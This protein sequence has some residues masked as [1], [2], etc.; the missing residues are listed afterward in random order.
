M[1]NGLTMEKMKASPTFICPGLRAA[2]EEEATLLNT[3]GVAV[4]WNE[5]IMVR[6]DII[7]AT[8]KR[9]HKRIGTKKLLQPFLI[10][11]KNRKN[12]QQV[13]DSR[14]DSSI[15]CRKQTNHFST[16]RYLIRKVHQPVRSIVSQCHSP[17]ATCTFAAT[18]QPLHSP[19]PN[20]P[21]YTF[22]IPSDPLGEIQE[23]ARRSN[24]MKR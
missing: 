12:G 6:G 19:L 5:W 23:L 8:K 4:T 2:P 1:Q 22:P 20:Q 15:K 9:C 13:D 24:S 7:N 16:S 3:G 10:K 18:V 21:P 11:H 14:T 17:E